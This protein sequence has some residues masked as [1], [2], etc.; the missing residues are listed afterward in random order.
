MNAPGRQLNVPGFSRRNP[1]VSD[2]PFSHLAAVR[3]RARAAATCLLLAT[4]LPALS[5][6][7]DRAGAEPVSGKVSYYGDVRPILQA[8]CKGCHQPA[9]AKGGY[10]MTDFK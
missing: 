3:R 7:M 10:V 4:A 1:L 9:K 2:P 6:S 8:N 5:A